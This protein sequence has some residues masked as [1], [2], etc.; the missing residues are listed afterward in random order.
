MTTPLQLIK[1]RQRFE[2]NGLPDVREPLIQELRRFDGML[3]PGMKVAV[4]VGS[5]GIANLP[6]VVGKIVEFVQARGGYCFIVPAMGSHGGAT[7]A[8]QREVL[9][10]YGV[11]EESVGAPVR[12]SMEVAELPLGDLETRIFMDRNAFEADGVIVVNRVKP[13][14]DFHGKYESGLVKMC[15]IGLGKHEG[16]LEI[17]RR[18]VYGLRNLIAPAARRILG[19]GKIIGGVALVENAREETMTVR[20][21]GADEIMEEE[22]LLLDAARNNMPAL[23]VDECDVLIIDRMGKEISGV[24]I[25]PNIIGRIGIAEEPDPSSPRIGSIVVCDLTKESHGNALGMGLA[26]V[27]TRRLY[28]AIDFRATYANVYASSFLDRAKVPVVAESDAEALQ[29]ALRSAHVEPSGTARIL[30]IRDT[31]HLEDFYASPVVAEELS[32]RSGIQAI[33]PLCPAFDESGR[34]AAF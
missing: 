7:A 28:S 22:P 29:Y 12:S 27:I 10:S 30:R 18:G 2:E 34:L 17:H 24:G 26:D 23:P 1:M 3:K 9:E 5:R 25:D 32:T 16:A 8:G 6:Q 14:T 11:T 15:V 4:A 31:L 13:H 20:A 21:L 19:F 33:S